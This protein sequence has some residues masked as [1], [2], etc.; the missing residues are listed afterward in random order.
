MQPNESDFPKNLKHYTSLDNLIA[1]LYNKKL[2][3]GDPDNWEDKNDIASV[4]AYVRQRGVP[5]KVLC[6]TYEE[7]TVHHWN[8]YAKG[9]AGCRIDFSNSLFKERLESVPNLV[10]RKMEYVKRPF[11]LSPY[12]VEDYPFLKRQP[13]QCD[14]EFR[15]VWAGNGDPPTIPIEGVIKRV[16]L[17]PHTKEHTETAI[18][19]LLKETYHIEEV[20]KSAVLDYD[21]WTRLF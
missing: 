19:Q 12:T 15:I 1:I 4:Q 3:L 6:L 16:T 14:K 5:V 8:T 7:E 9:A 18:R 10:F 11:D 13:Y 20:C 17:S 21:E 2:H